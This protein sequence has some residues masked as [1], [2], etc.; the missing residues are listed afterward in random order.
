MVNDIPFTL[1]VLIAKSRT[2]FRLLQIA[3][4]QFAN[5]RVEYLSEHGQ[6]ICSFDSSMRLF[7]CLFV[8]DGALL[9]P[10]SIDSETKNIDT[11][12]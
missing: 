2:S 7:V 1:K 12:L 9:K 10:H 11:C 8:F 3:L 6:C 4:R 5:S